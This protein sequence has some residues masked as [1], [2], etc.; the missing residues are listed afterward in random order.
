VNT[1]RFDANGLVAAVVQQWDT[2]E[3][4]MLAWMDEAALTKTLQ[5][6]W[7]TFYS[8]SRGA[9]WVKGETSGNR[10]RVK[11][12]LVDCDGDAVLVLVDQIGVACHAG[13]RSCFESDELDLQ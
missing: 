4:L 3:V 10:Q 12:V 11:Q 13:T 7:A 1:V 6:G 8:R 5:T 9:Q 2:K